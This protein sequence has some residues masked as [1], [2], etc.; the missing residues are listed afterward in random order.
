MISQG[1]G[2]ENIQTLE[3][4]GLRQMSMGEPIKMST[5]LFV[6]CAQ[7]FISSR[8]W[9]GL[10]MPWEWKSMAVKIRIGEAISFG[11]TKFLLVGKENTHK[12]LPIPLFTHVFL[13]LTQLE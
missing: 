1:M 9:L 10:L 12:C 3:P 4:I 6:F 7:S 8:S 5:T 2:S 13:F 11:E